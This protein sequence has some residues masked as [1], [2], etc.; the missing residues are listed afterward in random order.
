MCS[1]SVILVATRS[2]LLPPHT[3]AQ[4]PFN[5]MDLGLHLEMTEPGYQSDSLIANEWER[6]GEEPTI[7][8]S[9]LQIR[10]VAFGTGICILSP[11]RR[12]L[13]IQISQRLKSGQP[14]RSDGQDPGSPIC[15]SVQSLQI[16][17]L[18]LPQLL[19]TQEDL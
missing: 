18:R 16:L 17:Y 13:I 11:T 15:V 1:D 19:A 3:T 5:T 8:L 2:H 12:F 6:W 14:L 9:T 4:I 10:R 7:D